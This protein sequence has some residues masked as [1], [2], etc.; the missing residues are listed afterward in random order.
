VTLLN[1]AYTLPSHEALSGRMLSSVHKEVQENMKSELEGK[2]AVILQ[3]GWS[4][5]QN[6]PVIS[7][8]LHT[9]KKVYFID[10]GSTGSSKKDAQYCFELLEKAIQRSEEKFLCKIVGVC[11]DNCSTMKA[12]TKMVGENWLESKSTNSTLI[13]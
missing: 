1:P 5:N 7:H 6:E 4:T 13:C 10:A 11:T 3:Y 2:A 9:S 8:C 12:M